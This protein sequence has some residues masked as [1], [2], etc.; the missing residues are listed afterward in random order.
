M[1]KIGTMPEQGDIVLIPIPFTDLS[2]QKRRPVI[3]SS[4]NRYHRRTADMVVVAMTSNPQPSEFAFTLTS[5]DLTAGH[6]NRPGQVRADRIDT[7]SQAIAVKTFGRVSAAV[8]AR[9][10]EHLQA[11]TSVNP[12]CAIQD[13]RRPLW[14]RVVP[15]IRRPLLPPP[16][17]QLAGVPH[18]GKRHSRGMAAAVGGA[19]LASAAIAQ[20]Q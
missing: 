9:I 8:L 10:R 2:T 14:E 17:P 15:A 6:L 7:L 16:R 5:D 4:N 20:A 11:L 3:V 1:M 12:Y 13:E 18:S 19:A